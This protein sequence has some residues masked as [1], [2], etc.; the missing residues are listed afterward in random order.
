M[1]IFRKKAA[2]VV[3]RSDAVEVRAVHNVGDKSVTVR[4]FKAAPEKT[5][6]APRGPEATLEAVAVRLQQAAH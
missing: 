5:E 3:R 6:A 4:R 1:A 2:R